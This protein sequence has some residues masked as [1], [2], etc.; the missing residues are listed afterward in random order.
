[1]SITGSTGFGSVLTVATGGTGIFGNQN[2][3]FN[4]STLMV[5]ANQNMCNNAIS[6]VNTL[7]M[8]YTAPFAPTSVSNCVLWLDGAD[9]ATMT[10]TSG[11]SNLLTWRDKSSNAYSATNF[12]TPVYAANIVGTRGVVQFNSAGF[13]VTIPSFAISPQ[14]SVFMVYYPSGQGVNGPPIEQSVNSTLN[15]GLLV[16]SG[17]SNFIIRTNIDPPSGVSLTQSGTGLNASWTTYSGAISYYYS[18]YSNTI[19]SYTGGT[20]VTGAFGSTTS[21]SFAYASPTNGTYYYFTVTVTNSIGTSTLAASSLLQYITPAI[22][23]TNPSGTAITPTTVVSN[24]VYSF[25]TVGTNN[26]V[27]TGSA[28]ATYLIVA[29]GGGGGGGDGG[30]GGA[31][32]LLAG[33]TALTTGTYPVVVGAGG[34]GG[35]YVADFPTT[36]QTK[37]GNSTF[38]SLIA[39][40]GGFG[41]GENYTSADQGLRGGGNGGSGGASGGVNGGGTPGTAV[42]GQ[43]YGGGNSASSSYACPGGGGAGGTASG[44]TGGVGLQN[45]IT[46]T[47]VYYAGG[48]GGS[49]RGG[50]YYLGGNGGGGYGGSNTSINGGPGTNGLGGGGGGGG[51]NAGSGGNG[52]SGIVIVSIPYTALASPTSPTVVIVNGTGTLT[53]TAASGA[54]SYNWSLYTNGTT[55]TG[56]YG[57]IFTG[58]SNTTSSNVTVSNL[59]AG[60]YYYLAVQS[61]NASGLSPY[62]ASPLVEYIPSPSSLTLVLT[63][64]NA[65]LGWSSPAP[66]ATYYY[67]LFSNSLFAYAG[68]AVTSVTSTS[69]TTAVVSQTTTSGG[70]YYFTVYEVTTAGTS[71]TYTSDIVQYVATVTPSTTGGTIVNTTS[72]RYHIFTANSN[73]VMSSPASLSVTAFLIGGGG[74]G[75]TSHGGGG[76]AGEVVYTSSS[77]TNTT[78][79]IVV[80]AGGISGSNSANTAAGATSAF[81][82]SANGGG[83]GGGDLNGNATTGGSGGGGTGYYP[84]GFANT[85]TGGSSVK[86][87]SGLGNAG[88]NGSGNPAAGGGGGGAGGVGS[89]GSGNV[90]G[91]GGTGTN[92]YSTLLSA[93][94]SSMPTDWQTV[95]SGGYIAGGGGGGCWA[96]LQGVFSVGGSG[97]GG[98]GGNNN[99]GVTLPVNGINYTGSGGGGGGSGAQR[100]SNG[101]IGLAVVVVP[102]PT[103]PST[104]TSITFS[105]TAGTA[106]MGWAAVSGATNYTWVLYKSATSNYL[107]TSNAT[108]TVGSTTYSATQSGILSG[109]YYY[110]TVYSSNASGTSPVGFSSIVLGVPW[111][112]ALASTPLVF[113]VRGDSGLNTAGGK[114]TDSSNATQYTLYSTVSTVTINSLTACQFG[115]GAGY[116][117]SAAIV[118]SGVGRTVHVVMQV[119]STFTGQFYMFSGP[120]AVGNNTFDFRMAGSGSTATISATYQGGP[121][122]T[123]LGYNSSSFTLLTGVPVVYSVI[124]SASGTTLYVNGT[125]VGSSGASVWSAV[126]TTQMINAY[127]SPGGAGG[128]NAY[129]NPVYCEIISYNG[130]LSSTDMTTCMNYLRTKWGTS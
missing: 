27:F 125:S 120:F 112:P 110:F 87:G 103:P 35:I 80:G 124:T 28:T 7:G 15:P 73:F 71:P 108:G 100:G 48:G 6:N 58:P 93:I 4:G 91:P 19:Y 102:L 90:G 130:A 95:T 118:Y 41:G 42:S 86:T 2:M 16:E 60:Y 45:T 30:G 81:S 3:T 116:G 11:T 89:G 10:T 107:G 66:T 104:P 98:S 119:P 51:D 126:T 92:T 26:L 23:A 128:I 44:S 63:G 75:G 25:T 20:L 122:G 56:Y 64:S 12:G 17:I 129:G 123:S 99:N 50:N 21:T 109:S 78:Y 114:W 38:N 127:G 14:M 88:G 70:Y 83:G 43:G 40:G 85:G 9:T 53:W 18:L 29:G 49:G 47:A 65:T 31:G 72:N 37:G 117:A 105:I 97:G 68:T 59:T 24:S 52:G 5:N 76:G 101:G 34:Q 22:Y 77:I 8:S 111:T 94:S 113:W 69:N 36:A 33:T 121:S 55:S 57:S 62:V 32:G 1:V 61:S 13:G 106:T 96:Q 67:R 115:S 46:G 84:S 79:S 74:G 39:Y 54:T 82:I